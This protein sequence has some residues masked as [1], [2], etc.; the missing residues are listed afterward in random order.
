MG[1]EF[2]VSRMHKLDG[3]GAIKAFCDVA[4]SDEFIVKG[5]RVVEGKEGLFVGLPQDTGK[6]GKWYD[7]AFPLNASVR[8]ALNA[9][10]LSAYADS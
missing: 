9:A 8:E 6:D 5:F 7:R 10:V 2:K 3:E 4:I 1:L